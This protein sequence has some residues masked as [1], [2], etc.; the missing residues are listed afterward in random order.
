M[1]RDQMVREGLSP[2]G[3]HPPVLPAG[4]QRACSPTTASSTCY[5]FQLPYARPR[6]EVTDWGSRRRR[7]RAW[8]RWSAHVH[9]TMLIGTSTQAGAFTEAIVRDMA[10]HTERPIIMP[11][12]NPTSQGRGAAGG[13]ARAGPTA[14]RWSPPAARSHPVELDDVTY[15]IAQ[16]NNALVFPGLGLGVTVARASRISDRMIAAAADAVA[17]LS[18]ATRPGAPLL[19]PMTDLRP[20]SAAVAIAVARDRRR[21]RPGPGRPRRPDPAG[22]PGHVA[23]G[24]PAPRD[25]APLTAPFPG[26]N[27]AR[28]CDRRRC[29][30]PDRQAV[31]C[32]RRRSPRWT[33]AGSRSRRRW[34][35][36]GSAVTRSTT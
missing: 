28:F 21:G 25:Q 23:P 13:P 27:H 17:K 4:P 33:W 2:R 18:D 11:L 10:A 6:A 32:A 34:S 24:V 12:S 22:A 1:M 19:P 29:P 7:D 35:G 26:G 8:P 31:R 3:G 36:R 5:D 30:H 20:V 15:H 14:G 16:A 9:P